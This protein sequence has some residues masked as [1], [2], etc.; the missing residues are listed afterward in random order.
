[1]AAQS[2]A[3]VRG[4][5]FQSG[6]DPRRRPGGMF[7]KLRDVQMH[8]LEKW[9]PKADQVMARLLELCFDEDGRVSVAACAKFLEHAS[10]APKQ[11]EPRKDGEEPVDA[12]EAVAKAMDALLS[13]PETREQLKARLE[14]LEGGKGT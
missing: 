12:G 11:Q 8:A 14:V 1:M 10:P 4:R 3:V 2:S 13:R 5:P 7:A 6:H 9:G